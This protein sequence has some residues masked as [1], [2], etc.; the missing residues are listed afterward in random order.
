MANVRVGWSRQRQAATNIKRMIDKA[1]QTRTPIRDK[2]LNSPLEREDPSSTKKKPEEIDIWYADQGPGGGPP[3]GDGVGPGISGADLVGTGMMTVPEV[4]V[5]AAKTMFSVTDP[6]SFVATPFQLSKNEKL[7]QTIKVAEAQKAAKDAGLPVGPDADVADNEAPIAA[8]VEG[9]F[10]NPT[11][12]D[13]DA[14]DNMG[15]WGPP[16]GSNVG[17]GVSAAPNASPDPSNA[18]GT[19]GSLAGL[20]G[21]ASPGGVAGTGGEMG[22]AA[23]GL[24]VSGAPGAPGD[25]SGAG[26]FGIGAGDSGDSG[27]GDGLGGNGPAGVGAGPPGGEDGCII[28]TACTAEDSPQVDITREYRD[29]VLDTVTLAGYYQVAALVVPLIKRFRV[30]KWIMRAGLVERIVDYCAYALGKR[31]ARQYRT[32]KFVTENFLGFCHIVGRLVVW[33]TRVSRINT[34]TEQRQ[35]HL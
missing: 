32:S 30:V 26:G 34:L 20:G 17:L 29:K 21:G 2:I 31:E 22:D 1:Y 15:G 18:F 10:G 3:G 4:A 8:P 27:I 12:T 24:G 33:S 23:A 35:E 16:T 11:G 19:V 7:Q 13:A 6:K 5:L 9:H 14:A 25:P 28:V